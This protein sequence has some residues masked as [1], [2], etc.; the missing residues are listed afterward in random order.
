L[1]R[2]I[3]SPCPEN[4]VSDLSPLDRLLRLGAEPARRRRWPDYLTLGLEDRHVPA[5]VRMA[6]ERTLLNAPER[7]PASWAPIHAWRALGQLRAPAAAAPLIL[8]L[9]RDL[10]SDWVLA[11]VPAVLGMIGPAVFTGATLLLFDEGADEEVRI[12]MA[13]AITDV[14]L[15]YPQRRGEAAALLRTQLQDWQGQSRLL[16]AYLVSGLVDLRET[17]AAPLM[18]AAF[19]ARAV[20]LNVNGDWEEVQIDLGLLE[21]RITPLPGAPPPGG[22]T[23]GD[24]AKSK[25]RRKAEKQARKRNR[26][27]K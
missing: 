25:Q 4:G 19:A 18:E 8:L 11:E 1:S 17:D 13:R 27:K 16:N 24:A 23:K 5:L 7:D 6:T 12:A 14:G 3:H 15:E 22:A 2:V 20:D 9:Q 10:E 26:K 21:E